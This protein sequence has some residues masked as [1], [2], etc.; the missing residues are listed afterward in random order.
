MVKFQ[1]LQ[2]EKNDLEDKLFEL[3]RNLEEVNE[4]VEIARGHGDLS[5]NSDYESAI[6]SRGALEKEIQSVENKLLNAEIISKTNDGTIGLGTKVCYRYLHNN[7]ER[8][9]T[10]VGDGFGSVLDCKLGKTSPIGLALYGKALTPG[11]RVTYR[12]NKNNSITIEILS[13]V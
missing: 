12:D 6:A 8:T 9:V 13:I 4:K 7:E 11:D 10:L 2:S 5:E 3:Q 1:M